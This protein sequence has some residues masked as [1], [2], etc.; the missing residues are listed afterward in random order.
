MMLDHALACVE[1]GW[2][3]FPLVP[4]TKRPLTPNGFKDASKSVF[5]VRKWWTAHPDA[6]IGLATGEVSGIAVIDVD[7]K[8][9]AKGRESLSSLNGLPPTLT[10]TTPSGGWHLYYLC[11]QGG[12]RSR[13]GALP[14]IDLKADGG[15]VVAPGS[16]IDGKPYEYQD[17]E[18]H[19]ASLPEQII[20][21]LGRSM[22]GSHP[23]PAP[24]VGETIIEGGRNSTLASLA[25]TMRRRGADA[26]A[27]TAAL[28]VT[29]AKRCRPPLPDEEVETISASI[30]RYPPESSAPNANGNEPSA[31]DSEAEVMPPGFTDDALALDFTERHAEGWRFVAGWGHWLQ[32]EGTRWAKETT[33]KAFDNARM[34]CRE[35]AA[36]CLKPKIAAKVASASTVAAVERMARAD[37]RHAATIDQWDTDP[38]LF[39][40][41]GGVVMLRTSEET[42]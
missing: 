17:A 23:A 20:E 11:P 42:I 15:Y 33:L 2:A 27:I 25:G 30:A 39:D 31:T 12:L 8:G 10:V 36:R 3:V 7:V 1:Q 6:N 22:N 38:W 19:I 4:N 13:N 14:G 5:A 37:R 35:A 21:A 32:W 9:G 18:E 34:I 41:Q 24:P 29:N 16:V 26:D 28:K 40:T